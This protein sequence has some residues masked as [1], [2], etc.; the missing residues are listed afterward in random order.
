MTNLIDSTRRPDISFYSS[1]RIDI[2]A[3]V[4]K[5]LGIE[6][7]DVINVSTDGY[8]YLLYVQLK[9]SAINGTH[10]AACRPTSKRNTHNFRAHSIRLCKA[11]LKAVGT[12]LG[13]AR[14]PIGKP[15]F[16]KELDSTAIP[17]ITHNLLYKK[18]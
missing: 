18:T 2:T 9:A 3:R 12:G 14:L 16:S 4:S 6:S 1:G 7:G 5:I 17:I 11:M 15:F 13:E 10:E 8:E